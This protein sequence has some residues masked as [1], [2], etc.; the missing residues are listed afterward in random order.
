MF[1]LANQ[2]TNTHTRGEKRYWQLRDI[3]TTHGKILHVKHMVNADEG[4][5]DPP[6]GS[7]GAAAAQ[8]TRR[9]GKRRKSS[10]PGRAD[11]DGDGD[12]S[13]DGA[14][15]PSDA[16]D[17]PASGRRPRLHDRAPATDS[18]CVFYS[19]KKAVELLATA[20][21]PHARPCAPPP[22]LF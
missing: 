1:P 14:G 7:G 22:L 11:D 8:K 18:K 10:T 2:H 16:E 21:H 4:D 9:A 6:G 17:A 19:L 3:C 15:D 20:A 5:E 12:Q 13:A